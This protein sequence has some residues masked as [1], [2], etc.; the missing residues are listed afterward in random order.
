GGGAWLAELA[1]LA[2]EALVPVAV[3]AALGVPVG[4]D[5]IE[6]LARWLGGRPALL[7]LDSC[8]HL[9]GACGG[10]G[11]PR[12]RACPRVRGLATGREPLGVPG[13]VVHRVGPLP[14]DEAVRLFVERAALAR[15]SFALGEGNRAAVVRVCARLDGLPLAVEL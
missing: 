14:P 15:P 6:A 5:P 3:A 10:G 2:D 8:E 13:E 7:L 12:R 4:G 1:G 9:V 11:A